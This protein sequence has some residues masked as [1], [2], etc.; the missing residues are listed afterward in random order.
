MIIAIH[1]PNYLP[2]LGF[3]DKMMKADVC[4]IYDD[5]QFNK[6]D[7]QHRNRI[8]IY[9]GWKWL[10]V[11]VEKTR[12]CITDINIRN[13]VKIN[14]MKWSDTH[15]KEIYDNYNKTPYYAEYEEELRKIYNGVYNRLI[16]L[17]MKLIR[18]LMTSFDIDTKLVFSSGYNFKSK[19]SQKLVD[20]VDALNGDVYL[21]GPAG[22]NYLNM[23]LFDRKRI[24]VEFQNFKHP[25]YRQVYKG[26]VPNMSAID[27]LF[28]VGRMPE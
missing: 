21:S 10:A 17:N 15:F 1:Q 8:R 11:P 19:S 16:D 25:I 3:F 14:N 20:I 12:I 2:Y 27:A 13:D 24:K 7:F 22:H 9:H 5:A 26:F 23:S 28:N 18:F 4:V 6:G